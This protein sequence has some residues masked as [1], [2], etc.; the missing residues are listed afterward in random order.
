MIGA[1]RFDPTILREYDI[2]GVIGKTLSATDAE[3]IGR[4]FGTLVAADGGRRVAVGRDGRVSW[5]EIV[6]AVVDGTCHASKA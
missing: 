1:H 2:R 5:P 3:A 6:A 4:A